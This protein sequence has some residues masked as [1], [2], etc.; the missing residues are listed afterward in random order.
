MMNSESQPGSGEE[1][2]RLSVPFYGDVLG[3][4]DAATEIAEVRGLPYALVP[5]RFRSP[6]PCATL[7]G[8]T[9]D[10]TVFGYY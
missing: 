10:G 4:V 9:H 8:V 1:K 7:Q 6:L 3:I 2:F 5:G